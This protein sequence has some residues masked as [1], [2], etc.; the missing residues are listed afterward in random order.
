MEETTPHPN[1]LPLLFLH[2]VGA[3][4]DGVG[5]AGG[6]VLLLVFR[7]GEI[8]VYRSALSTPLG[9]IG[10]GCCSC[11]QCLE[12]GCVDGQT[13]MFLFFNRVG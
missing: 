9:D 8:C 3:L 10:I 11:V 12:V 2:P 4:I 1:N 7:S 13:A 5:R 6:L